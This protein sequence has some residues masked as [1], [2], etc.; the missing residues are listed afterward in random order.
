MCKGCHMNTG[1]ER[2]KSFLIDDTSGAVTPEWTVLT[3]LLVAMAASLA[4]IY[5][6]VN[7][8]ASVVESDIQVPIN[9][10]STD[11]SMQATMTSP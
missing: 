10:Q 6:G 8:V 11:L 4:P 7:M 3:A 9:G 1:F 2:V 5:A